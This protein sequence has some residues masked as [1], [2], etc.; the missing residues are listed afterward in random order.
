M[1]ANSL[2][3][4]IVTYLKSIVCAKSSSRTSGISPT[5]SSALLVT[6]LMI[7]RM[8]T[9][10]EQGKG[11]E[12][13]VRKVVRHDRYGLPNTSPNHPPPFSLKETRSMSDANEMSDSKV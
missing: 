7:A 1:I 6:A 9:F 10:S 8:E 11:V 2:I 3:W 13:A 12:G 5:S 4:S